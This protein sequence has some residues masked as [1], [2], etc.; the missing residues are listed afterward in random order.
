MN[1]ILTDNSE[2][3]TRREKLVITEKG[4]VED[5]NQI[6]I[7][8]VVS[9]KGRHNKEVEVRSLAIMLNP[10]SSFVNLLLFMTVLLANRI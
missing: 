9:E 5:S 1:Q 7:I 4:L 2:K 8:D 3:A 10:R 6:V